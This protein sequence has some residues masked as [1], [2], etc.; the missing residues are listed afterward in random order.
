MSGMPVE[1]KEE[2]EPLRPRVP[3]GQIAEAKAMTNPF[4]NTP[5]N[6]EKGKTIFFGKGTCY[7]CHGDE[8]KGD[9]KF[10]RRL[11]PGPRD[12]TNSKWQK[13]RTDGEM[14]WVLKYGSPGSGMVS[15]IPSDI[16]EEEAW[17]AIVY[18]RTLSGK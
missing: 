3:D 8:G 11:N 17:H 12:L 2:V 18:V 4:L 13:A 10:G 6:L 7:K 16:T 9:G 14:F 1:A 15:L 5:E